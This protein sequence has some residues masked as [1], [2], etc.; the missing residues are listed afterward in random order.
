MIEGGLNPSHSRRDPRAGLQSHNQIVDGQEQVGRRVAENRV[1]GEVHFDG[2]AVGDFHRGYIRVPI[3][4]HAR[5]N[6]S[7]QN[8]GLGGNGG[9]GEHEL[10]LE[11]EVRQT[12]QLLLQALDFCRHGQAIVRGQRAV[13]SLNP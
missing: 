13:G 5:G 10:S 12:Q 11:G 3:V 4:P 6:T 9:P 1:P 8:E 2:L 7:I